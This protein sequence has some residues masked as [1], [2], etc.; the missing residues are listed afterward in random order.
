LGEQGKTR[1]RL[2][3][4]VIGELAALIDRIK[5]HGIVGMTLLSD[6]K[7]Q[8]LKHS[9][10]FR[11][12]FKLARDRAEVKAVELGIKFVRFQFRDLRAKSASD[13]ESMAKARKLLG[14][15]TETM[16]SEYVRARVAD[17][18][19]ARFNVWLCQTGKNVKIAK[20][21]KNGE[22]FFRHL[23]HK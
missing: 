11:S 3:I 5:S 6:P 13:M 18:V 17:K 10:Y 15:S 16:T 21:I 20:K 7:G 19:S 9:G 1:A 14:H 22:N 2:Q 8:Q 12:Q 4:D 23:S